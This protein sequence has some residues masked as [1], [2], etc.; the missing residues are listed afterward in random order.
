VCNRE[1]KQ[2][3]KM[4]LVYLVS[5]FR[6]PRQLA[7]LLGRLQQPN[8]RFVVHLDAKVAS[9]PFLDALPAHLHPTVTFV[10][11]PVRVYW[12]GYSHLRAL[13]RLLEAALSQPFDYAI[14]LSG[15]DYP[16][17]TNEQINDFFARQPPDLFSYWRLA[18]RPAWQHKLRYWYFYDWPWLN[19]RTNPLTKLLF[20][21]YNRTLKL[22]LPPR[23]Y[24]AALE[25]FGGADH[26]ILTRR[27]VA[28]LLDFV[29][30]HP[31]LMHWYQFSDC[32]SE[33]VFHTILLNAPFR[34]EIIHWAEYEAWSRSLTDLDRAQSAEPMPEAAFHRRYMD[35]SPERERPAILDR[36]DAHDLLTTDALFARKFD[37]RRSARLLDILDERLDQ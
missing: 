30:Q 21:V 5:A 12:K 29:R 3:K 24:P 28:Y 11:D 16:L 7:R 34:H 26:F 10:S 13:L 23:R 19:P 33:H 25:P 17:K 20:R 15:A 6:Q 1:H 18:D 31:D 8:A 36:R 2:C 37:Q 4:M 35:W 9:G 27:S 22:A 14:T 32:P